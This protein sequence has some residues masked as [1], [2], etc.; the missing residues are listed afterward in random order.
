MKMAVKWLSPS[1]LTMLVEVVIDRPIPGVATAK[2]PK[3]PNDAAETALIAEDLQAQQRTNEIF[4][5]AEVKEYLWL[6]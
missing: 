6:L 3:K 5:E 1:P 4:F 2:K